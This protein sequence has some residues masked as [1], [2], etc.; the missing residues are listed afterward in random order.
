MTRRTFCS[1]AGGVLLLRASAPHVLP[2]RMVWDRRVSVS[3]QR[4]RAFL[5]RVWNEAVVDFRR[6]GIQI[7]VR[8]VDGEIRLSPAGRPLITGLEHSSINVLLTDR[9]P[10][11]WD[12]GRALH[13]VSTR[14]EGC[15]L[16]L[17]AVAYAHPH[18]IPFLSVNTCVHELLHV[19]LQDVSEPRPPGLHG[20]MR[21]LR[22]D[23]YATR[24][25]L[26]AGG[27]DLV[28]RIRA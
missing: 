8:E 1:L 9:V 12:G 4:R 2:L 5:G 18:R 7:A 3:G 19:L 14:Y 22:I 13:G 25:W 10:S 16:C 17:I 28:E 20:E 23:W 11:A 6:A 15:D 27:G 26:F 21:E 24:L